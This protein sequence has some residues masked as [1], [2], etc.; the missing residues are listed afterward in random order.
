MVSWS[1]TIS[2][3]VDQSVRQFLA[4]KGGNESDMAAFVEKAVRRE[5]FEQKLQII[6]N[7]NAHYSQQDIMDTVDEALSSVRASR[8]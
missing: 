2:E 7:R 4:E 1:L 8:S 3:D 5:L 6:K